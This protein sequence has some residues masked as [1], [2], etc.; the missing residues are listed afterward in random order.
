MSCRS[1]TLGRGA[2]VSAMNSLFTS[3]PI[4]LMLKPLCDFVKSDNITIKSPCNEVSLSDSSLL[5]TCCFVTV[6]ISFSKLMCS[7]S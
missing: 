4:A 3:S 2:S 1:S 7:S 5:D 6:M